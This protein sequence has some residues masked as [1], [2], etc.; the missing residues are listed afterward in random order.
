MATEH[1]RAVL[2]L[3][4]TPFMRSLSK[5]EA[6]LKSFGRKLTSGL[7][8][9]GIS[10]GF[11][12]LA[13][14][15]TDFAD[16]LVDTAQKLGIST[17]F[18]QAWNYAAQQNGVN[19]QA[20]NLALQRFS[21]RVAEAAKGQ[22]ELKK[23]IEELGIPLRDNAGNMRK[24]T[25]ILADYAD[26]IQGAESQQ[27]RLRLA[28][29]AFDSEGVGMVAV[30]NDGSEGLK[31]M[32]ADAVRLGAVVEQKALVSIKRLTNQTR[33][34]S[35]QAKGWMAQTVG[36][37]IRGTEFAID[38]WQAFFG[39]NL[40]ASAAGDRAQRQE[41]ARMQAREQL[42]THEE[43]MTEELEKQAKLEREKEASIREQIRLQRSDEAASSKA[44]APS[45]R[46]QVREQFRVNRERE[47]RA[48]RLLF[49]ARNFSIREDE[50]RAR[51]RLEDALGQ[52]SASSIQ[53]AEAM[54]RRAQNAASSADT[55]RR[56]IM[57]PL[58]N[59]EELRQR[60]R[61]LDRAAELESDA[62]R[63]R[64]FGFFDRAQEFRSTA[65][66]MRRSVAES[67]RVEGM[68]QLTEDVRRIME[69]IRELNQ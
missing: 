10:L 13:R 14:T 50:L 66:G 26:A 9:I 27:E 33:A 69:N 52:D 40:G 6:G 56:G 7:G 20:S 55:L 65:E 37:F 12:A 4:V 34:L 18:L 58:E 8:A 23:T 62:E 44:D 2:G 59:L 64:R 36:D 16:K 11:R 25:E 43:R 31:Q 68:Q 42:A 21:R 30:L 24:T 51:A 61:I 17:D 5:A 32:T 28:F 46:D 60:R 29:K 39:E 3:N 19:I 57:N 22:G 48:R 67:T 38:F 49:A 41:Q 54:R 45:F 1:A 35:I 15:V 63:A 47:T 53:Q